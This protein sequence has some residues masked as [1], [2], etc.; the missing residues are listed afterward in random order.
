MRLRVLLPFAVFIDEADVSRIVAETSDGSFGL[1]TNRLDCVAALEPGI[2]VYESASHDEVFLAVDEGV[3]VKTGPNVLVAVRRALR[4]RDL[5]Q[6][7][8]AVTLQFEKQ[9]A[10]DRNLR[11]AMARLESG[12]LHRLA[13]FEHE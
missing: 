8:D 11:S 1:L 10:Q 7:R 6:L 4:G 12:F 3:M 13:G 2:L 5:G 9:D